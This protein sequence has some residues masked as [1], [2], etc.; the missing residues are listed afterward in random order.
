MSFWENKKRIKKGYIV[1][2]IKKASR[3]TLFLLKESR[4]KKFKDG[5]KMSTV[6]SENTLTDNQISFYRHTHTLT[7]TYMNT[8]Q[9]QIEMSLS[10]KK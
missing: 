8:L 5:K 7:H 10:G 3:N 6:H 2:C 4:M 1:D 9:V